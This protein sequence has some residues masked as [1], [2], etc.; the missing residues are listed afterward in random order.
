MDSPLNK[1][2]CVRV[3]IHTED[4]RLI[5]INPET[6]IPRTFKRFSGMLVKLLETGAINAEEI[7]LLRIHSVT[8]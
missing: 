3:L 4:E 8:I 1:A 7:N 2:G 6:K 5:E